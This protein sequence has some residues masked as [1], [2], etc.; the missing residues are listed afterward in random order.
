[1]LHP[2]PS[3]HPILNTV[4]REPGVWTLLGPLDVEYGRIEIR[5]TD[6]G[7]KC[8]CELFGE[9]IGWGN[10]LKYS[11]MRVHRAYLASLGPQGGSVGW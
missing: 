9:L 8:R 11:C 7:V 6:Q 2:E 1:M 3:W 5:R 4:E 10:S